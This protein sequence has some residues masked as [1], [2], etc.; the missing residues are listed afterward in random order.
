[1]AKIRISFKNYRDIKYYQELLKDGENIILFGEAKMEENFLNQAYGIKNVNHQ[2]KRITKLEKHPK[3]ILK[4]L[5]ELNFDQFGYNLFGFKDSANF[6][7]SN[8]LDQLKIKYK[9]GI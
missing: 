1:M 5:S 2:L 7:F 4:K 6:T 8:K 9:Y 3:Y